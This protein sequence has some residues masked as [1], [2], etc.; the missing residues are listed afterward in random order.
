VVPGTIASVSRFG[1]P[2]FEVARGQNFPEAIAV[3]AWSVYW[4][5]A[6]SPDLGYVDGSI[7]TASKLG[8]PVRVLAAD[9]PF[10]QTIAVEGGDVYWSDV[11]SIDAVAACGGLPRLIAASPHIA[12]IAVGARDVFWGEPDQEEPIWR[13][14]KRGGI[15]SAITPA[16]SVSSLA[17]SDGRIFFRSAQNQIRSVGTAGGTPVVVG[18][19]PVTASYA[20]SIAVDDRY[21][22]FMTDTAVLRLAKSGGT[23]EVIAAGQPFPGGIAVDDHGV[24][25]TAFDG[26]PESGIVVT[27]PKRCRPA[28]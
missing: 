20:S 19:T 13:S 15:A 23:A 6:G 25:W 9:R 8:G 12:A 5:N 10:P 27:V 22:Y 4:A 17:F 16:Q 2:V 1:G 28:S 11:G 24:Y 14:P 3:D 7:A 26:T 18:Q 21:V